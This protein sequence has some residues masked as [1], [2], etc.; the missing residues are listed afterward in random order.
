[1]DGSCACPITMHC[2]GTY[3]DGFR[4]TT[5]PS[6]KTVSLNQ[7]LNLGPPHYKLKMLLIRL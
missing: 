4:Q 6:V 2:A 7:D 5:E 1:M 3:L